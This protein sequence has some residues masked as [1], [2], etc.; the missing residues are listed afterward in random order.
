MPDTTIV[1][2][3]SLKQKIEA[4]QGPILIFGAGGFIGINLFSTIYAV[5]KDCYAVTHS[6]SLPWRLKVAD[7]PIENTIYCDIA[8]RSSVEEIL[9]SY[10]PKTI[11][12]LAAYG[13]YQKQDDAT[14][15]Y[16]TN[17]LGT[18]NILEQV[19][20]IKAYV[21][22]GSSSEYGYNATAPKEDALAEP[23]SHYAV[24]K[25]SGAHLIQYLAKAK[26]LPAVNLRLYSIYGP[27]E[28]PDRLVSKLVEC[29]RK[30]SLPSLAS[31][32]VSRDFVY[33]G[34]CVEAFIHAACL[35][36]PEIYGQSFNIAAGE[37]VTIKKIV[38]TTINGFNLSV[39]PEWNTIS[40]RNWDLTD[41]YGNAEKAHKFLQWSAKTSLAEGLK[42]TAEW[43]KQI[44]YE[45]TVLPAFQ[46]PL[47]GKISCVIAC[48]KDAQAIP[49]MYERITTTFKKL[50]AHYEIIFVND[51]S[52]DNTEEILKQF[53]NKDNHVVAI[54][55][56][57]N[58]GSQSA[59]MS[60]MEV[61]TGDAVV[62]MDGDLQDP[63]ELIEQFYAKWK[64][65]YDVVYGVREKRET[66]F[67]LGVLYKLFY[68]LF[69]SMANLT[70]PRNAGDFSLID[71]KVVNKLLALPETEQFLR[72]LRAWVGFKQT[73]VDYLRPERAFGKSTNNWRKN[74]WWAKKAIFSFSFVP[75]EIIGYTGA[76][77]TKLGFL[78]LVVELLLKCMHSA[79]YSWNVTIVLLFIFF[80]GI[81]LLAV[82]VL[83]EYISKI[84][85]ETKK[86]PKFIRT[87]IRKGSRVYDTEEKMKEYVK[88]H[89][90]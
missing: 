51:S 83:G 37:K 86:R 62:L 9:E 74:I 20:D 32:D 79:H 59:F 64:Q 34:D 84:V 43:Q 23:N 5:R 76:L 17:L 13:A 14:L 3:L 53:C 87:S 67:L 48:Y 63:P 15:I 61:A 70:I 27:W 45:G 31:P 50:P 71:R 46:K 28:E 22:A 4:L 44:N 81:Q 2:Q 12:N 54:T 40:N 82:S 47:S 35:M 38:E 65:G 69:S 6:A 77:F 36:K 88:G 30:N 21:H 8:S 60:G 85:E 72:G 29:S 18:L 75:I 89:R 39:A 11:F 24:S 19:K 26:N 56:S 78:G 58:F 66:T 73:G 41:W 1:E 10:K 68:K 80:G 90:T 42:K 49:V 33:V 57:R 16:E 55:H 52:P 7:V 25:L